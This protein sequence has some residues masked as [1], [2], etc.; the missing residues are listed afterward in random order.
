[1]AGTITHLVI[2]DRLLDF[3]QIKNP[4]LF[5]C[6]N[7]A[8]DAVMARENYV[9]EMKKYTHFKENIPT[10]DLHLPENYKIYLE[11]FNRFIER[12]LRK[13]G[14]EYELYLGYVVH[15]LA[16]EIFILKV[17]D[18][19][20]ANLGFGRENAKYAEYFKTFGHDVDLNDWQLVREYNFRYPMPD[21]LRQESGYEIKGYITWEELEKSKNYIINKNF[22]TQHLP[23][24]TKVFSFEENN[25]FIESAMNFI[26]VYFTEI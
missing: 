13:D 18:L 26:K 6:G 16:D 23:E 20:V 8:P 22:G 1:M 5:Y 2:A 3:F 21:I 24:K 25:R 11:R 19:H 12:N 15:M 17:R 9:R 14:P 7:L 4:A 10:D